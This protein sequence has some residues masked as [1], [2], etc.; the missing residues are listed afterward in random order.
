MDKPLPFYK[1]TNPAIVLSGA[2]L[3]TLV[4]SLTY[5]G[6]AGLIVDEWYTFYFVTHDWKGLWQIISYTE[7]KMGLYYVLLKIWIYIGQSGFTMR[8][9]SVIFAVSSIPV[10]YAIGKK[11]FGSRTAIISAYILS[12]NAFFIYYAREARGYSLL[13]LLVSLS[14]FF[15]IRIIEKKDSMDWICYI[16]FS[17]FA[18][19]THYFGALV[20]I[21]HAA[22]LLFLPRK[23]IPWRWLLLSAAIII[24]CLVPIALL[25]LT[26]DR[27]PINWP[28]PITIKNIPGVF[29]HLAGNSKEIWSAYFL[30]TFFF[31]L[32]LI[33]SVKFIKA[34]IDYKVSIQTWRY[35]FLLIWLVL[36][37]GI[38][39]AFSI[40]VN[41]IYQ[42]RYSIICLPPLVLLVA[43]GLSHIRQ[44][45]AY[46]SSILIIIILSGYTATSNYHYQTD[47]HK[48]W[49]SA[50]NYIMS[51]IESNDGIIFCDSFGI[52]KFE[53][54]RRQVGETKK[55]INYLYPHLD[56]EAVMGPPLNPEVIRSLTSDHDRVWLV[57]IKKNVLNNTSQISAMLNNLYSHTKHHNISDLSIQLYSR[58]ALSKNS[59]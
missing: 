41:P 21:A 31:F 8:L 52:I 25:I 28:D 48:L 36:P 33:S 11:L 23:N 16:V 5:L 18:V 56:R 47:D 24:L 58:T 34:W 7:A 57:S 32:C 50:T 42:I 3:I 51:A 10:I 44:H 46:I 15:F 26:R 22:S 38:T 37:I 39:F 17:V 40:I 4:L 13:L 29:L 59:L 45:W 1:K 19:Y 14:S 53:Y 54:Y 43:I 6:K 49:R 9:L 30:V 35:L 27:G 20:L 12:A 55:A 2:G